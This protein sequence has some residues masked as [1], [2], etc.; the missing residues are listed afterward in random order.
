VKTGRFDTSDLAGL[1]EFTRRHPRVRPLVVT[2]PGREAAARRVGVDAVSW[3][4]FRESGPDR[5]A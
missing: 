4:D 2:A 5:F 1:F 3:I